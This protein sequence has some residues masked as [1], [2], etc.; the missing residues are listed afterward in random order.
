MLFLH[1]KTFTSSLRAACIFVHPY[2]RLRK[3][4]AWQRFREAKIMLRF[5]DCIHTL[6]CFG[7]P[8]DIDPHNPNIT[9]TP[10]NIIAFQVPAGHLEPDQERQLI[11]LPTIPTIND[12]RLLR[13]ILKI[14]RKNKNKKTKENGNSP[15]RANSSGESSTEENEKQHSPPTGPPTG[16]T[17]QHPDNPF[18]RAGEIIIWEVVMSILNSR[19]N[20]LSPS[21]R[22]RFENILTSDNQ[23]HYFTLCYRMEQHIHGYKDWGTLSTRNLAEV[24]RGYIGAL[25]L[26]SEVGPKAAWSF[27]HQLFQEVSQD[28]IEYAEWR[29]TFARGRGQPNEQEKDNVETRFI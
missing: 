6:S 29:S 28:E 25:S 7:P 3:P 27:V 20:K 21:D 12:K 1:T 8:R 2:P 22:E 23:A 4:T 14:K 11:K 10:A 15:I 26:E 18:A 5:I 13:K 17:T 16:D 19:G 9:M 24:F